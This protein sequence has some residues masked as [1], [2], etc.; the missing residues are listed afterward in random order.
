LSLPIED[1]AL[2]GDCQ[3]AALVSRGG[4]ID[5]FCVPRFD[6]A[7]CFAAL[8]GTEDHGRWLVA[9]QS[10]D[11]VVTRSYYDHTLILETTFESPEG[12]AKVI[13]FMA[14][15]DDGVS[16][17]VRIVVGEVGRIAMRS[18]TSVRFNYGSTTPWV[19]KLP[20]DTLGVRAIAGPSMIVLRA[21]FELVGE[22]MQTVGDFTVDAGERIVFV[23][24]HS[25]SHL[26]LPEP[27]DGEQALAQTIAFWEEWGD[28]PIDAGPYTDIVR[29]SLMV[30][31]ALTFGPTGGIVAAPTT[32]LP[33]RIG[34]VRN[35][36][37]R[38]CWLRDATLTLFALMN[39]G[40]YDE[41][42]AWRMWLER[43]VAG[44]AAQLRIM[45]GLA[46]EQRLEEW[47]I[48][49][50]PGYAGSL[51]VRIGNAASN[52]L[53]LDVYGQ[54]IGALYYA[55]MGGLDDDDAIWPFQLKMLAHLET[56]WQLPDQSIWESRDGPQQF[57]FS[58]V[59][60]WMAFDRAIASVEKFGVDGPVERWR[61][62][63]DRIHA[64]VCAEAFDAGRNAFV[65]SYGST[66]LDASL[67]LIPL[68][69]FLPFD[70]PRVM[71]T[72]AA[73]ERELLVDGFVLRYSTAESI[74]GLPPGEGVFLA[75]SFWLV[76]NLRL[77]G[78][79]DEATALFERLLAVANDVG[80][81]AE[82]YDPVAK[83][84]LGNFPQ[85]FSHVALINAA[86]G[87]THSG[88]LGNDALAD[89]IE[90]QSAATA[91][92]PVV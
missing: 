54:V 92:Q 33:E 51:P 89:V 6:G 45:Y 48:D 60:V 16:H 10:P 82:E 5:W 29:R 56:I 17:I 53:Q 57:T 77:Q 49:G 28:R 71:G 34:G 13:D 70:D 69:G 73:I 23:L 47:Q 84:Q 42:R 18:A 50:L 90:S 39:A 41:A 62:L 15:R 27:V 78:R 4:S 35:W 64:E 8:L 19:T 40:Y 85:A 75:C 76:D 12:R 52:Q 31:K 88:K 86:M 14:P 55:R 24:T 74:D 80:L 7:A 30:L 81:L 44:D 32:S 63:R 43:A 83:R 25:P 2:I 11:A 20:D 3:T 21:P 1:Y 36:D 9:A 87:L 67:L 72:V 68:V 58:K 61:A 22:D 26:P 46:G 66:S 37:Y 91:P 65:Q 59:M 79:I 38:Y